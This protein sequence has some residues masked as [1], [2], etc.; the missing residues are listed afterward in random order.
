MTKLKKASPT[1]LTWCGRENEVCAEDPSTLTGTIVLGNRVEALAQQ[2]VW[3]KD[4]V[5]R[6][7]NS[8]EESELVANIGKSEV[9]RLVK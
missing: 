8:V 5:P 2:Y 4:R 1:T 7:M 9:L 3:T 6:A